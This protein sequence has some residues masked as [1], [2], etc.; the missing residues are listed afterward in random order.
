MVE[1]LLLLTLIYLPFQL[2]LNPA[3]GIDLASIRIIIPAVFF[4]WLAICLKKKKIIV[5]VRMETWFLVSFIFLSLFSLFYAPNTSWGLRKIFFLL[6]FIPLYFIVSDQIAKKKEVAK[7]IIDFL[8]IG[9]S[10]ISLAG[11]I[12]FCLPFIIG[13]D[14]ALRLW[15]KIIIPFL[16]ETF[17]QSVIEHPS[18]LVN[19]GGRTVM[20]SIAFFPDPHMFAYY[21]NLVLPWPLLL[22]LKRRDK[23]WLYFASTILISTTLL[24]TFSRG[25]YLGLIAWTLAGLLFYFRNNLKKK[26][27]LILTVSISAFFLAIFFSNNPVSERLLST[28]SSQDNSNQGRVAIWKESAIII[29]NHLL[30][31]GIGNYP[32]AIKPSAD[33]REPIYAHNLYLDIAAE[34]GILNALVFISL[35]L[36]SSFSFWRHSRNN[37]IYLAGTLS[38]I[39]FSIHSLFETPLYSVHVLPVLLILF[40][41]S[42]AYDE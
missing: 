28:F 18:W 33:Y 22:A 3:D 27:V 17:A 4:A 16:G 13:L 31:V 24:L 35:I 2:A 1:K 15:E 36:F 12:Q 9:A 20:R 14:P 11:L 10:L 38:L 7:K 30:G 23:R 41:L 34:T 19:L 37:T 39:G 29:Y 21:L 8:I 26:K 25:A 40:S 42:A 6:N 5:P 32:L